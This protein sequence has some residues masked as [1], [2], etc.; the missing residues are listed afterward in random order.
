MITAELLGTSRDNLKNILIWVCFSKDGVEI[1]F[2]GAEGL[3]TFNGRKAW[4]L[5]A[6]YEN[7]TGKTAAQRLQWIRVNV[8]HQIGNIIR[9][10]VTKEA[11]VSQVETQLT[12]LVGQTIQKDSITFPADLDND[13]VQEA[14]VTLK[15]DGIYTV[16]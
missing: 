1:E 7:F 15:D 8:E 13:G 3:L 12:S 9:E 5:V 6:R 14:M 10:I 16:I 11:L 4:P 2:Y